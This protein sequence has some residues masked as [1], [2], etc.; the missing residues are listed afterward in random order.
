[1]L[2]ATFADSADSG[3][4][5]DS[6]VASAAAVPGGWSPWDLLLQKG[7]M[8]FP[9]SPCVVSSASRSSRSSHRC[10]KSGFRT[11]QSPLLLV[12]FLLWAVTR[13]P[14]YML[15]SATLWTQSSQQSSR[16]I[17]P[18][19]GPQCLCRKHFLTISQG[20]P[21]VDRCYENTQ[22][23]KG[24]IHL[25]SKQIAAEL[26]LHVKWKLQVSTQH[27]AFDPNLTTTP[28]LRIRRLSEGTKPLPR[29]PARS[30]KN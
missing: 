13:Q 11:T 9:Y 14:P 26:W 30:G 8:S 19:P 15:L 24:P 7:P 4:D 28:Q 16:T 27:Q 17:S 2:P 6:A 29:H 25:S 23:A 5:G 22:E 20:R 12:M 3:K 18:T 10:L 21:W 1:M